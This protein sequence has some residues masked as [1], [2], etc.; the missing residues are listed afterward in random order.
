[1]SSEIAWLMIAAN[2]AIAAIA[3]ANTWML[4]WYAKKTKKRTKKTKE[5]SASDETA[6][7]SISR[8]A[9]PYGL[10]VILSCVTLAYSMWKP[11]PDLNLQILQIALSIGLAILAIA[12]SL[13]SPLVS[14]TREQWEA[15][16]EV[17]N[18]IHEVTS[19]TTKI[20]DIDRRES[21]NNT[22]DTDA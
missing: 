6:Q 14:H 12:L 2:A 10:I 19:I 18:L 16:T 3:I 8:R 22:V 13:I 21:P 1:M 5:A 9:A 20:A 11:N 17:T 4:A 15:L 7:R